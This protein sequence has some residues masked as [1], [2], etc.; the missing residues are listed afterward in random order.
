MNPH[1]KAVANDDTA[2]AL[3]VIA[4]A[5]R[6]L[7]DVAAADIAR[8]LGWQPERAH[9]AVDRLADAKLIT[10]H[11]D[12]YVFGVAI[13]TGRLRMTAAGWAHVGQRPPLHVAPPERALQ[14]QVAPSAR[15]GAPN[16]EKAARTA[17]IGGVS[18][19][20]TS[21]TGGKA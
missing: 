18:Y 8:R 15:V 11:V 5:A 14:A 16:G 9:A 1:V 19:Q 13:K 12:P 6:R 3:A 7:I 2:A 17:K 4:L 20:E 10:S 21:F